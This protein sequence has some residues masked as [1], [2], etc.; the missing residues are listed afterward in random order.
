[1]FSKMYKQEFI[2]VGMNIKKQTLILRSL[3][4]EMGTIMSKLIQ[5]HIFKPLIL[6][7]LTHLNWLTLTLIINT[8]LLI[9]N[10]N[11]LK[12]SIKK[13][14]LNKSTKIIALIKGKLELMFRV[15][16]IKDSRIMFRVNLLK[17]IKL[18]ILIM[19]MLLRAI[20]LEIM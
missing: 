7:I 12:R 15:L 20:K 9:I 17:F 13:V 2:A 11:L 8:L 1:M 3:M 18:L 19:S 10:N 16:L 6:K 14:L 4:K 5:M